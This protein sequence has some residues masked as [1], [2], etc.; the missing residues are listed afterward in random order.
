MLYTCTCTCRHTCPH[1]HKHTYTHKIESE[2]EWPWI[3]GYYQ[4]PPCCWAVVAHVFDPSTW[5]A[6]AGRVLS[7]RPTWSSEWVLGQS[8][9]YRET[10]SRNKQTNKKT[11]PPKKQKQKKKKQNKDLLAKENNP[12][13][14]QEKPPE[15]A[16]QWQHTPLIWAEGR[17]R[18]I[19]EFEASLI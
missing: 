9:L 12:N 19:C 8:G 1:K 13:N 11:T 10:L 15:I 3:I 5:E 17:G 16:G 6:E 2:A 18:W 4:G 14:P 7:S